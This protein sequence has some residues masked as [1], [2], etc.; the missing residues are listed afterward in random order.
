MDEPNGEMEE[1]L[2][3]SRLL[4]EGPAGCG[5]TAFL[6]HLAFLWSSGLEDARTYS[7]LFP[8]FIR[9]PE[10]AEHIE[11]CL[12]RR[13][14]PRD[15]RERLIDF[16]GKQNRELNWGLHAGFFQEKLGAAFLLLDGLNEVPGEVQRESICR[17]IEEAAAANPL[18]RF[19][20]T[21]R[22]PADGGPCEVAGFHTIP[23]CPHP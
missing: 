17:L 5:K 9:L 20:V 18:S 4:I 16:L 1:A 21:T 15:P 22:P 19:V 23:I 8:I 12:V 11:G 3:N 6:R 7:L 14:G 2:T 13:S 10:L